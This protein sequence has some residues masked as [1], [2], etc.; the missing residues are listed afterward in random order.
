[1]PQGHGRIAEATLKGE[2]VSKYRVFYGSLT[3]YHQALPQFDWPTVDWN[4]TSILWGLN[5]LRDK[6]HHQ[7][8]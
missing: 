7:Q 3:P 8:A 5:E 1:M 4:E 2:V 6:A